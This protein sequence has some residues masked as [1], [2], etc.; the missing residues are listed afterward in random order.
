MIDQ[1]RS[2]TILLPQF[3]HTRLLRPGILEHDADRNWLGQRRPWIYH[4]KLRE[5]FM[6]FPLDGVADP[7]DVLGWPAGR[8][9]LKQP[10][11]RIASD[12]PLLHLARGGGVAR[13]SHWR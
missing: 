6:A 4:D 2:S 7:A 12:G 5:A 1:T 13:A 9:V 3:S 11:G 10:P 8:Q